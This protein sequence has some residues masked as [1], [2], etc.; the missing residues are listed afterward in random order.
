[1]SIPF[2]QQ[3]AKLRILQRRAKEEMDKARAE[4]ERQKNELWKPV[5]EAN[6][7]Y[8]RCCTAHYQR[9]RELGYC[10]CCEK[11]LSECH[12]VFLASSG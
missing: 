8:A 11:P 9:A 10:G 1:M 4:Y 5:Y 12:C 6:E 7:H 2:D 3:L